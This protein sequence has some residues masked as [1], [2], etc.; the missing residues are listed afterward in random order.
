M[1]VKLQSKKDLLF[2][3][4][5]SGVLFGV[6]VVSKANNGVLFGVPRCEQSEQWGAILG[7]PVVS[8]AN[9]GVLPS[10][11]KWCFC[12]FGGGIFLGVIN[13]LAPSQYSPSH[14]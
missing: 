7:S 13:C 2:K 1:W 11:Q 9:N 12:F 4:I 5:R 10:E 6:P 8:K 3:K 14:V